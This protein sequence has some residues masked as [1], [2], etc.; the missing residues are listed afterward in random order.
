MRATEKDRLWNQKVAD[1]GHLLFGRMAA[2]NSHIR[3]S[4]A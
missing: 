2:S 4:A 3:P 1:F